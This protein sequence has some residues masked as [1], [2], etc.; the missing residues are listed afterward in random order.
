ME[1]ELRRTTANDLPYVLAAESDDE[2]RRFIAAWPEDKHRAALDD[3]NIAHLIIAPKPDSQPVGFVML[4]GLRG[5]DRSIEFLRIVVTEKGQGYG[6]AAVRAIKRYAFDS[7][8]AHRLWLDVKEY[9]TRA[10]AVYEKEGFRYE[11]MLR[12][13]RQGPNGFESLVVM[14]MLEQEYHDA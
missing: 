6:R 13:C 7:L 12:E 3:P 9:N 11:G 14:S 2:N 8:S 4:A 1:I 5:E 10:R